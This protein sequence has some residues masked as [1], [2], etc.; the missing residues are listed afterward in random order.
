MPKRKRRRS[1]APIAREVRRAFRDAEVE[2]S[3]ILSEF[4]GYPVEVRRKRVRPPATTPGDT[5]NLGKMMRTAKRSIA[6]GY[7]DQAPL[8]EAEIAAG[9]EQDAEIERIDLHREYEQEEAARER[10]PNPRPD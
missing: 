6:A 5:T 4:L 10:G 2:A 1:F 7:Y 3:R 8:T 9:R